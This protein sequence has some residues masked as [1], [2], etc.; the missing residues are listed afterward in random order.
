MQCKRRSRLH[1]QLTIT[2]CEHTSQ[3]NCLS[4]VTLCMFN[5]LSYVLD[6]FATGK[7]QRTGSSKPIKTLYS[8][9]ILRCVETNRTASCHSWRVVLYCPGCRG[10]TPCRATSKCGAQLFLS[11]PLAAS[12]D[13]PLKHCTVPSAQG[14]EAVV[15]GQ[16]V[17]C[18]HVTAVTTIHV[19]QALGLGGR[20]GEDPDFAKVITGGK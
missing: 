1:K 16:E 9:G 11:V 20:V 12:D 3:P 5:S 19:A 8:G 4:Q 6:C 18:C 7:F 13:G 14:D 2:G 17:H 15:I 10:A